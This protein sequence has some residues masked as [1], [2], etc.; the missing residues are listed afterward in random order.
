MCVFGGGGGLGGSILQGIILQYCIKTLQKRYLD[1]FKLQMKP[2]GKANLTNLEGKVQHYI[3][4][5]IEG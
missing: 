5:W 1:S 4:K 2:I 3:Q